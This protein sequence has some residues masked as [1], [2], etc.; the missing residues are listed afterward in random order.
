MKGGTLQSIQKTG[1]LKG[2]IRFVEASVPGFK[3]IAGPFYVD[4]PSIGKDETRQAREAAEL[5]AQA[6]CPHQAVK[7]RGMGFILRSA[8]G[9]RVDVAGNEDYLDKYRTQI[10]MRNGQTGRKEA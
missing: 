8:E 6:G 9:W 4:H 10:K 7:Y 2:V 3:V 1:G 5:Q